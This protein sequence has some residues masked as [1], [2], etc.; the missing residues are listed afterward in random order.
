MKK[1]ILI[2]VFAVSTFGLAACSSTLDG[3]GKDIENIGE[4]IQETF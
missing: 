4:K 2:C 3:A 1:I